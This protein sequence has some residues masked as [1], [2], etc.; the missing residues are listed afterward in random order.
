M[1]LQHLNLKKLKTKNHMPRNF[2]KK[3]PDS[4]LDP[5]TTK[6]QTQN[7]KHKPK[8]QKTRTQ[9]QEHRSKN[10]KHKPI[11]NKNINTNLAVD[12]SCQPNTKT[13][14]GLQQEHKHKPSRGSLINQTQKRKHIPKNQQE[15]T[16][17]KISKKTNTNTNTNP[18][19]YL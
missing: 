12:L 11:S 13:Q 6:T 4:D 16:Y 10:T 17:P 18:S 8:T 2:F 14:T 19:I 9:I 5:R 15:N 7:T 1:P 3:I